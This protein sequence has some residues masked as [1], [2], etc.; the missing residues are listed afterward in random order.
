MSPL[1]QTSNT[2]APDLDACDLSSIMTTMQAHAQHETTVSVI[3]TLFNEAAHIDRLLESLAAQSRVPDEVILCD[4][5]S[6]DGTPARIEAWAAENPN[7]LPNLRVIVAPGANISRGR[8]LAIDAAQGP[9]I[10]ATDAGVRLHPDWLRQLVLPWS[11]AGDAP[12]AVAGFFQP[13]AEGPFQIALAATT[14]PL[15]DEIDPNTFLP[16]SRSVAFTKSAWQAAGGYPEWLDYCEDLIFDFNINAQQPHHTTG[17]HWAP[18]ALVS[19]RPRESLGAFF[20]QYYRYARGDG[21]AD[22]WRKRHAIR[23]ATYLVAFPALL[24]HAF[25]GFFAK[26]LGWLGLFGGILLYCATPLRRLLRIRGSLTATETAQAALLIPLL[27]ATG[28]IAKML[29]YPVGLLWRWRNR[30]RPEI[31]WRDKQ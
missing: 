1:Y 26:W 28:D 10:A 3:A 8:N 13:D 12:I 27:R 9:I 29:G 5:G 11:A 23:Y 2:P 30:S 15:V 16:S 7:R 17:F 4:G 21:K 6:S 31:H 24:G 14:L 20:K 22:L 18:D 25:F 19:F